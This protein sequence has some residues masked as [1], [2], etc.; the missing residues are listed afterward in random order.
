MRVWLSCRANP[1]RHLYRLEQLDRASSLSDICSHLS[2]P[3]SQSI[4]NITGSVLGVG[5]GSK[6][7]GEVG[8]K[9]VVFV[10]IVDA[11]VH[12]AR[13]SELGVEWRDLVQDALVDSGVAS[14]VDGSVGVVNLNVDA[15]DIDS[16]GGCI[17]NP[18][19][20]EEV[21]VVGGELLVVIVLPHVLELLAGHLGVAL[22]DGGLEA[23]ACAAPVTDPVAH[24]VDLVLP[25]GSVQR[26]DTLRLEQGDEVVVVLNLL[27]DTVLREALT[28]LIAV[29]GVVV[30]V[31]AA[32]VGVMVTVGL[33]SGPVGLT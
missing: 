4:I 21:L 7:D 20:L 9:V 19:I 1:H 31:V 3:R 22:V 2:P 18:A 15:A 29:V 14:L 10:L 6:V 26:E 16:K 5:L 11:D 32:G 13:V 27:G 23:E 33:S 28:E 17:D 25:V 30:A 12:E 8:A 24:F